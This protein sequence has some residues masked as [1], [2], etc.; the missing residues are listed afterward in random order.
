MGMGMGLLMMM[1]MGGL[2]DVPGGI[3][4][5]FEGLFIFVELARPRLGS[6]V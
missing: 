3:N 4:N 5:L 1:V 6:I 2:T